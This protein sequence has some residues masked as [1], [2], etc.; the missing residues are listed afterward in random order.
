M[1]TIMI[2]EDDR[3]LC[4]QLAEGLR[5]WRFNV[6]I[7]EDFEHVVAEF[8]RHQP[9]LVVM[10]VN[11]PCFDGFYWTEQIRKIS[12]V[13]VLFLS[14][15]DNNMDII[16]AVNA[17]ADDYVTKPFAMSVLIA[18]VQALLRRSYYYAAGTPDLLSHHEL[19]LNT[20]DGTVFY[21]GQRIELTK[22]EHKILSLLLSN[23]GKIVSRGRLMRLLWD[24]DEFVN[25]NTLTV[26]INRLRT[27]LADMGL[28]DFITT[29]KGQGYI[30]T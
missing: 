11:L 9:Q 2:V 7:A 8:G 20:G 18:K 17:G 21:N 10:D 26:N 3:A 19:T 5:K 15:R 1:Y 25:D 29:K 12:K 22:N 16:M 27:K 24:N 4:T 28:D 6:T 13:P 14:S 30:I 23:K